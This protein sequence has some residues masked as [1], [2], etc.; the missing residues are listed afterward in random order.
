MTISSVVVADE[1]NA[2]GKDNQLLCHLPAD[3]RYFKKLTVGFPVIMGRKTFE[4]MGKP[5]V[6]RRNIVVTHQDIKI[7]GCEVAHSIEEAIELCKG[8]EKVSIIGG[9]TIYQQSLHLTD[10]IYLTRIHH[11]FEADTYF[12]GLEEEWQE[13]FREDHEAD[14]KN[15]F[16]YS[17]ITLKKKS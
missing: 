12:P 8:E 9:A 16:A 1:N 4:S 15:A 14:E 6:N 5:L 11:Q 2:I 7:E 17:F 3:L 13:V 10:T